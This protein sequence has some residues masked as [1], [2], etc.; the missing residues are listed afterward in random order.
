MR[1]LKEVFLNF[2]RSGFMSLISIGTIILAVTAL[3]GYFI[4]NESINY[5]VKQVQQ[6]VEVV[7]FLH[8]GIQKDKIDSII[9]EAQSTLDVKE[10]KFISKEEAFID[11]VK[12]PDIAG[13][14]KTFSTNPLPDSINVKLNQYSKNNI[15]KIV[16]LFDSKEGIEDIQYGGSEIENMINIIEVVKMIAGVVGIIFIVSSLLVVSNIIRLTVYARRQDIYVFRMIGASESFIRMPFIVE[17]IVH[18]FIGGLIGWGPLYAVV[19][20]LISQIRK[21]TGMDLS[22]FYLFKPM[23]FNVKFMLGSIGAGASLGF[24]GAISAQWKLFK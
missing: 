17:G 21:E 14:M 19:N 9:S 2:K 22:E 5:T 13:I 8:D 12:D 15:D 6:K 1:W 18:G 10:I 3:G 7:V 24:L 23:F 4:I 11:Y 20:I 16:K